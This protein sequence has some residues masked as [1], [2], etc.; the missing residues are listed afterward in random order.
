MFELQNKALHLTAI[1][2]HSIV[3]GELCVMLQLGQCNP[4]PMLW[5]NKSLPPNR[6]NKNPYIA[7]VILVRT[8]LSWAIA[9][10]SASS[11]LEPQ[12]QTIKKSLMTGSRVKM[13]IS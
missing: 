8:K 12:S 3:S 5:Y 11:W 9:I 7:V 4:F 13:P 10:P 1:P 2:P 6:H